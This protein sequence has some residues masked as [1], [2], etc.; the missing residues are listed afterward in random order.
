MPCVA[1]SAGIAD[2]EGREAG[3]GCG[4]E[5]KAEEGEVRSISFML[6][7]D[8]VRDRSKTVTRRTGWENLKPGTLLLAVVKGMGLKKGERMEPLAVICVESVCREPLHFMTADLGYGFD[9]IRREG[10]AFHPIFGW[11]S[12]WVDMFCRAHKDCTPETVVTRI[13]F[14]YVP[15]FNPKSEVSNG[16]A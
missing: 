14:R 16:E 10:F 9:E 1:D 2:R 6:T 12:M 7:T 8:Q 4:E 15:G 5:T 11:P 3:A 13:E